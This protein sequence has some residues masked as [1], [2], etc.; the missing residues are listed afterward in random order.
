MS[1]LYVAAKYLEE[2]TATSGYGGGETWL[3]VPV[4]TVSHRPGNYC[5]LYFTNDPYTYDSEGAASYVEWIPGLD[6]YPIIGTSQTINRTYISEIGTLGDETVIL[7]SDCTGMF[8]NMSFGIASDSFYIFYYWN[9][10][11]GYAYGGTQHIRIDFSKFDTSNVTNMTSMFDNC[12][13]ASQVLDVFWHKDNSTTQDKWQYGFWSLALTGLGTWD[14]SNVTTATNMFANNN[15]LS[16]GYLPF[17][18]QYTYTDVEQVRDFFNGETIK[19]PNIIDASGVFENSK[20]KL[21]NSTVIFNSNQKA[22]FSNMFKN[23]GL[24]YTITT[25][26]TMDINNWL[27]G[28]PDADLSNMFYDADYRSI[29]LGDSLEAQIQVLTDTNSINSMFGSSSDAKHLTWIYVNGETDWHELNSKLVSSEM[30]INRTSLEHW[31]GTIDI[32]KA[33]TG[34]TG[35]FVGSPKTLRKYII[36]LKIPQSEVL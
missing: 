16:G 17:Y 30:F 23:T 1:T 33:N 29:N 12:A 10:R 5:K 3:P 14:L 15:L 25:L 7:P 34:S 35:Y 19:F 21:M 28:A 31:D 27:F 32:T 9:Y 13:A 2:Y 22:D 4:H 24:S 8:Q 6:D 36:Y 11:R 20:L 18:N 26:N